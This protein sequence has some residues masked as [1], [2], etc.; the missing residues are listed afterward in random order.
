MLSDILVTLD[1]DGNGFVAV[2]KIAGAR[3][4]VDAHL[5]HV[6]ELA[7]DRRVIYDFDIRRA[8]VRCACG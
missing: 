3:R 8:I 2:W 1:L 6:R 4:V 7:A 5:K